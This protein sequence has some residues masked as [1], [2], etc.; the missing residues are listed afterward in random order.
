MYKTSNYNLF[1]RHND[2]VLYFN[3]LQQSSFVMSPQEHKRLQSKWQDPIEFE[4]AF[5]SISK[6]FYDWGFFVDEGVNEY[7][8]LKDRYFTTVN[9]D[10]EP[11][12]VINMSNDINKN[13]EYENDQ[14]FVDVLSLHISNIISRKSTQKITVEWVI[15]SHIYI[16]EVIK[17]IEVF[18]V[19]ECS[20]REIEF[21]SQIHFTKLDMARKSANL[22]QKLIGV[23]NVLIDVKLNT[24]NSVLKSKGILRI[25]ADIKI[26]ASANTNINFLPNIYQKDNKLLQLFVNKIN[27]LNLQ[28]IILNTTNSSIQSDQPNQSIASIGWQNMME[29]NKYNYTLDL[30][31][32]VYMGRYIQKDTCRNI[33]CLRDDGSVNYNYS[34]KGSYY[35]TEW[36]VNDKCSKCR[37]LPLLYDICSLRT[38][39]YGNVLH[40]ACPIEAQ[41]IDPEDVIVKV[42]KNKK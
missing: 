35:G 7:S 38:H 4:F 40:V 5:P 8:I 21:I 37:Y 12:I 33:G 24:Q 9:D 18:I 20:K 22:L 14:T 41:A 25:I 34:L 15:D 1:I 2:R 27:E 42:F 31:G 30:S 17:K 28:N 3:T 32:K 16:K 29:F 39:Y 10:T 26:I 19:E 23:K 11:H 36:F 13:V 6:Q